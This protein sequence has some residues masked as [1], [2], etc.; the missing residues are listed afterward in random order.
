MSDHC[1]CRLCNPMPG[2]EAHPVYGYDLTLAKEAPCSVCSEKIGDEPYTEDLALARFGDMMLVH[3]RC[4][5]EKKKRA[6]LRMEKNWHSRKA[7]KEK[8]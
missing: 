3:V 2:R 4:E 8:T 7:R 6:R 1:E 5:D